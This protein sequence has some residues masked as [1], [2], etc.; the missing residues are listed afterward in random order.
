MFVL[1]EAWATI[2]RHKGRS[3]LA[4]LTIVIVSVVS[5]TGL[6]ILKAENIATTTSYDSQD[7]TAIFKLNRAKVI[8][9]NEGKTIDWS[10]YTL[11]WEDYITYAQA[12][13]VQFSA[14]YNESADIS[15]SGNL[16]A[17][18]GNSGTS[19]DTAVGKG[20]GALSVVGF[21]SAA[22]AKKAA[23]GSFTL[24][25][26]KA[27]SYSESTASNTVLISQALAKK[28][29]LKVGDSITVA[30]MKTSSKT[31]KLTI[32]GIYKNATTAKSSSAD[33]DNPDNA[34]YTS[35]Y[36][37]MSMGLDSE[38]TPGTAG[39]SLNMVFGFSTPKDFKTFTK[40]VRKAG[41]SKNYDLVSES[42]QQYNETVEP[43]TQ[44]AKWARYTML[45]LAILGAVIL[46]ACG[47]FTL[48]HRKQEIGML[49][50]L[51]VGK[52]RISWRFIIEMFIVVIPSLLVGLGGGYALNLLVARW[53][54]AHSI[55]ESTPDL[56]VWKILISVA[57]GLCALCIIAAITRITIFRKRNLL[58]PR[59]EA[60]A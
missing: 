1:K 35:Y 43:L 46:L 30:D 44:T 17:V 26:G 2:S 8:K 27:V 4:A 40:N 33:A 48:S 24:T 58:L 55:A 60:Q 38:T 31:H 20:R 9:A 16:K 3:T 15:A 21:S 59:Q 51:G 57:A 36:T 14:D 28:N 13:V 42:L 45:T 29:N 52:V 54:P 47:F 37:F 25:S 7:V 34:I 18:S 6:S 12:A 39:H 23:N 10:K 53:I 11:G 49:M 50:T 32:S 41:L 19:S 22:S 56:G 5:L